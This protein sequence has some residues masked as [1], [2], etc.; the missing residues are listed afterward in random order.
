[1]DLVLVE[2]VDSHSYGPGWQT[3]KDSRKFAKNFQPLMVSVG[4]V[5]GEC[6]KYLTLVQ[7][8][9]PGQ[10]NGFIKIPKC[11]VVKRCEIRS[12]KK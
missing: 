3:T 1:M 11:S 4:M 5:F 7:S 12:R 9:S 6:D 8:A 10:Y 2:W